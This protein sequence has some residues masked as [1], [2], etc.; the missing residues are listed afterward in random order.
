MTSEA[1]KAR[2]AAKRKGQS[3]E[4]ADAVVR[5]SHTGDAAAAHGS[6]DSSGLVDAR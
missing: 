4:E 6:G 1:K 3:A 2:K 5:R